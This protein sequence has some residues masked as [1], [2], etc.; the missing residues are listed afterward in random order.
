MT[1]IL[2]IDG[3]NIGYASILQRLLKIATSQQ[4]LFKVRADWDPPL[5]HRLVIQKPSSKGVFD[6]KIPSVVPPSHRP[7]PGRLLAV[8]PHGFRWDLA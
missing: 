7:V 1:R 4:A 6:E 3:N 8:R 2:L 5:G